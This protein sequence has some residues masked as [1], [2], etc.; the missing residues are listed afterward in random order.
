MADQQSQ[1]NEVTADIAAVKGDLT[2]IA[3]GV[4][5]LNTQIK[6]LQA[7]VAAGNQIDLSQLVADA[8]ALKTQADMAA[9]LVAPPTV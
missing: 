7:Q 6:A 3:T 9:G 2:I 5:A 8:D 4:T 1:I